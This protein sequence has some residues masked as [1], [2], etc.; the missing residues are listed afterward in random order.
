MKLMKKGKTIGVDDLS[1]DTIDLHDPMVLI[2]GSRTQG[3]PVRG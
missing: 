1:F 3:A 2:F